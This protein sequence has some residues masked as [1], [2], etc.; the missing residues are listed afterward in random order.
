MKLRHSLIAATFLA[1]GFAPFLAQ[2]DTPGQHPF[3][4]HA[5]SDL[6]GARWEIN[7]RPGN[8]AMSVHENE[9]LRE[10]DAAIHEL[11]NA[12]IDDGKN[13]EDH[14]PVD[15][16]PDHVGRL[17]AAHDLL[18]QAHSDVA[19]EEDDPMA[20]GLQHRALEHIDAAMHE[21]DRA[22]HDSM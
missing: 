22:I 9:A 11:K 2:A 15:E 13:P 16:R 10:I 8:W 20:R 1:S 5:L 17:H 3:Y 21:T 7:H 4:L 19:R 6:R 18:M 12:S 14:P